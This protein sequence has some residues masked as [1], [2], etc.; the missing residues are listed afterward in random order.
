MDAP[1]VAVL[2]GRCVLG[3]VDV[4]ERLQFWHRARQDSVVE[5]GPLFHWH[6]QYMNPTMMVAVPV[7]IAAKS[8]SWGRWR[9][10]FR[11]VSGCR[12]RD[13]ESSWAMVKWW[14]Q[15][16]SCVRWWSRSVSCSARSGVNLYS[17]CESLGRGEDG[18][19]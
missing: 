2:V 18:A 14:D 10:L 17:R 13:E 6:G 8:Q 9:P 1:H 16:V 5:V 19:A 3:Q 12:V 4:V 15:P 7:R 11:S